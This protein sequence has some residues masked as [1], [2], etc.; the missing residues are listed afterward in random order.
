M[1]FRWTVKQTKSGFTCIDHK[2]REISWTFT[3]SNIVYFPVYISK[4][5]HVYVTFI[6][7]F[8][9]INK[10]VNFSYFF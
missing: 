9:K 2:Y 10:A 7:N 4:H 3:K 6:I 5:Q 1:D 8:L